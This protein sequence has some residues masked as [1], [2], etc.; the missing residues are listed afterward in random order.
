MVATVY[1]KIR[2]RDRGQALV[3]FALI[4]GVLLAFLFIVIESGRIFQAWL[5]VQNAARSGA[6]YAVTGQF[7]QTGV[8]NTPECPT[9]TPSD[10]WHVCSV[11][12]E[13]LR[14]A[15]GINI[16]PTASVNEPGAFG[17]QVCVPDNCPPENVGRPGQSTRVRVFY[18]VEIIIPLFRPIAKFIRVTG[19]V[20]LVTA[21]YDQVSHS[22]FIITEVD[23]GGTSPPIPNSA[24]LRIS[25]SDSKDPVYVL[26]TVVY[27]LTVVNDGPFDTPSVEVIDILPPGT[28][29]VSE[30][31]VTD[32]TNPIVD[33]TCSFNPLDRQVACVIPYLEGGAGTNNTAIINITTQLVPIESPD[34]PSLSEVTV[35]NEAFVFN[36]IAT[37]DPDLT[38]N[39]ATEETTVILWADLE[40]IKSHQSRPPREGFVVGDTVV[41]NIHV[42]NFGP[43]IAR[44]ARVTDTLPEGLKF[45][46]VYATNA[47]CTQA[48]NGISC[49]LDDLA[50]NQIA[51][52]Q[53]TAQAVQPNDKNTRTNTAIV[54]RPTNVNENDD[55]IAGWHPI[56]D[57]DNQDSV[58]SPVTVPRLLLS[59]SK[60]NPGPGIV[61]EIM[62]YEVKVFNDGP[63]IA[64]D[65]VITDTLYTH[66]DPPAIEV[67]Y[68]G[69]FVDGEAADCGLQDNSYQITCSLG[70]IP[71]NGSITLFVD[72]IPRVALNEMP[73][74]VLA[75]SNGGFI[76]ASTT[77]TTQVVRP[78]DLE[79]VN[80]GPDL[81]DLKDSDSSIKYTVKIINHGPSTTGAFTVNDTLELFSDDTNMIGAVNIS[82]VE[83]N[84][85]CSVAGDKKSVKCSVSDLSAL[86]NNNS[87]KFDLNITPTS[88]GF[89]TNTVKVNDTVP[90]YGI[91][92]KY[93]DRASVSTEIRPIADLA[94]S[95][96]MLSRAYGLIEYGISVTNNGPS[97][98]E[99][100][101]IT[102]TVTTGTISGI[103]MT[104]QTDCNTGAGGPAPISIACHLNRL[105]SGFTANFTVT[106]TFTDDVGPM[107]ADE[108]RVTSNTFDPKPENNIQSIEDTL[109]FVPGFLLTK[110]QSL[111]IAYILPILRI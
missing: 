19:Q 88:G 13:A 97:S 57:N 22:E 70:D 109:G 48:G 67:E 73:N 54:S 102:D 17:T 82:N 108:A 74:S 96:E 6:R 55:I 37:T 104:Y 78:Y 45:V 64:K 20:E 84:I 50:T 103:T 21:N 105:D 110:K 26:D 9:G 41:Y 98:A 60:Q 40:L 39:S 99:G 86:P 90:Q 77:I 12:D 14:T 11:K 44:G 83:G 24:D 72:V 23:P 93:P 106:I 95:K 34:D 25:K 5:T 63:G 92:E 75:R 56:G 107:L 89:L 27:S 53:L 65:V 61:D 38:N 2:V 111:L 51:T 81:I 52:I 35:T 28:K 4:V 91:E 80:I 100:L 31:T 94:I 68:V 58:D 7:N 76:E 10:H 85:V 32:G 62:R 59:K 33:A 49:N 15:S 36:A 66:P 1:K 71:K 3:E 42:Q 18:N 46:S 29:S 69:A 101:V 47:V 8:F 87:V 16:D 43:I 79:V 30:I